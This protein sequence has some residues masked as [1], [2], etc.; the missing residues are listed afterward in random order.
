[1]QISSFIPLLFL[2]EG[3]PIN[4]CGN[5]TFRGYVDSAFK[6]IMDFAMNMAQPGQLGGGG[7]GQDNGVPNFSAIV[8]RKPNGLT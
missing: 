5:L 2:V 4:A 3:V 8:Y 1:M 7:D 6:N